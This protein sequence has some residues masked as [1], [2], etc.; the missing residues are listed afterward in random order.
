[1]SLSLVPMEIR[2]AEGADA[3]S[4]S[5]GVVSSGVFS[6]HYHTRGWTYSHN[7]CKGHQFLYTK[8]LQWNS[9]SNPPLANWVTAA[10]QIFSYITFQQNITGV[11]FPTPTSE[12]SAFL[13][14]CAPKCCGVFSSD[15]APSADG[16]EKPNS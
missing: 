13:C 12:E 7:G 5:G 4:P 9:D 11:T 16:L 2:S 14:T 8:N 3:Q 10:A 6:G 1:M 15:I